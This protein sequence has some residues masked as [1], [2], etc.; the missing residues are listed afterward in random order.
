MLKE[1]RH[2]KKYLF[3]DTD[4]DYAVTEVSWLRESSRKPK[5]KVT[6]YSRQ[7]PV[8]PKA[9]SPH[10]S[11]MQIKPHIYAAHILKFIKLKLDVD[12]MI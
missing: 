5:P 6:E 7:A 11:C 4:T 9:V 1:K 2:V 8:K 3:S 10:T 12:K